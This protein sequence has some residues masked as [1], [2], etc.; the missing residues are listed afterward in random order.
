MQ[1]HVLGCHLS[2]NKISSYSSNQGGN[3]CRLIFNLRR[4]GH[5]TDA[6]AGENNYYIQG[7]D[8]DVSCTAWFHT[9]L[10]GVIIHMCRRHAAPTQAQVRLHWTARRSDLSSVN[11]RRSCLSCCWSKGVEWPAKRSYVGLV[12]VG[13]Q[14]QAE[15]ILFRR[16][17][18]TVWL[19]ITF[20]FPSHYLPPQNSR[21]CNSFYCLGNFKN[22]CN[23][24]DDAVV[25]HCT[26]HAD[27]FQSHVDKHSSNICQVGA[28]LWSSFICA[29][30]L[31]V[32]C[33]FT[34]IQFRR[35]GQQGP[36]RKLT[37]A[38]KPMMTS[39]CRDGEVFDLGG[40]RFFHWPV[41][42]PSHFLMP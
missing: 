17:Y 30:I 20:P 23:D 7:G 9:T 19:S 16:C 25:A 38:L 10:L 31:L 28:C 12:A 21:P 33:T 13:V 4:C 39:V 14:E 35:A 15:D 5:I 8:A 2:V 11:Y 42:R 22:V 26:G 24:D 36:I 34:S 6:R 18:E 37:A 32:V 29:V 40:D 1:I 27:A 41:V 3:Y